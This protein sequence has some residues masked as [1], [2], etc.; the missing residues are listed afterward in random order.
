MLPGLILARYHQIPLLCYLQIPP[1][2]F[3]RQRLFG[4]QGVRRFIAVSDQTRSVWSKLG[5]EPDKIDLVY[6]GTDTNKFT[7]AMDFAQVRQQW[8]IPESTRV[9]SFV[10][11]LDKEKGIE[12]LIKAF[13]LVKQTY[14]DVK[15]LIAGKPLLHV[16]LEKQ[17]ECPEEGM[18]YQRSLEALLDQLGIEDSIAFL[19]HLT[20][21]ASLYQISDVTL[22]P[23][24]WPEPFGR[25][26]IEAMA[27][28]TPVIASRTG[29]IPEVLTGGF[30]SH[31]VDPG[32]AVN[33]AMALQS[34]LHWRETDPSLGMRSREYVLQKFSL[35]SMVD[36][37][38]KIL[39]KVVNDG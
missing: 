11:R 18:K 27:C 32:N 21:T 19:G 37:I 24:L 38:E 28:G 33:L 17:K 36:G 15:L 9:I 20:Q 10:G 1:F 4:L 31:L 29:G 14:P 30:Q 39:F 34:I 2:D 22:M 13:A 35:D 7:P 23:S 26:I 16:S 25:V 8:G 6:N 3:N 5:Y 12:T